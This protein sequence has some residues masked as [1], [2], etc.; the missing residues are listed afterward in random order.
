[1][2]AL[3][4]T[5]FSFTAG[6]SLHCAVRPQISPC[7]CSPHHMYANTI[8]VTCE[9]MDS[10]NHVVD[11]LQNKFTPD[12]QIWLRITHSQM[13]DFDKRQFAEMN[14]NIKNLRLNHNNLSSVPMETFQNLTK[15]EVLSLADNNIQEIPREAFE[16]MPNLG[17]LD[18]A[19]GNI[20]KIRSDDFAKIKNLQTLVIA[21]NE[22]ELLEKGC[23]PKTLTSLHIGRNKIPSLN[24]T[25]QHLTDMKMLF[26]NGNN[27]T[28]LEDELPDAPNM[29]MLMASHNNLDKLPKT[30]KNLVALD[31]CYFN[32]N[33]L[34]SLDGL[35][36]HRGSLVRLYLENNE[37]EYLA[38]DEFLKSESIDEIQL[39]SNQ[40][41]SLN[42]S[43]LYITNLRSVNLS[44]NLLREFSMQEIY[45]LM[46]LRHLD[47]SH[48]R[49]EKLT[50]RIENILDT[51]S[52]TLLYQ[53]LLGNNLLKSL[54]G[55]L[56]GLGNLRR[57]ILSNNL[58]ENIYPEDFDRM[59]ELEVLDLSNNRLKSLEAFSKVYLPTLETLNASY[60]L[61]T[62]TGK[63]FHGLN[64]LC[65]A[66]LSHNNIASMSIDLVSQT[67]CSNHGVVS[68]LEIFL[69]ENPVLCDENLPQLVGLFEM[70]HARLIGIAHCIV[71]QILPIPIDQQSQA[72]LQQPPM[73]LL[74]SVM[75]PSHPILPNQLPIIQSPS[76]VQIIVPAQ[77]IPTHSHIGEKLLNQSNDDNGKLPTD[78][79][80][81]IDENQPTTAQIETQTHDTLL[82]STTTSPQ[83]SEDEID[84]M[85]LNED[86]YNQE[87][88]DKKQQRDRSD[89]KYVESFESEKSNIP[90]RRF[91]HDNETD[92]KNVIHVLPVPKALSSPKD[93]SSSSV[94]ST[95]LDDE[96][97]E[98]Q[99]QSNISDE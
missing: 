11:V 43:L 34:R 55:V 68:K 71:P 91:D 69:Q 22:I 29:I 4:Y 1:M 94:T 3:L 85:I 70:Y 2:A 49:I 9:K 83:Y 54:D 33:K 78:N 73:E 60:N 8:S 15:V 44:G 63:D 62:T 57:L 59:E 28:T 48:N 25:L 24:G 19:R 98:I 76:I 35:F 72:L 39:A 75:Q 32:D 53:L 86:D 13:M 51:P 58:L 46:K 7:T 14:M 30:V 16:F 40:I 20:K 93:A 97:P 31:T 37:I 38:Q 23:F 61:L 56:A 99:D 80:T 90:L 47:L 12:F 87:N 45:G 17:T 64:V 77:S 41:S 66:D 96:P 10:F 79:E 81:F 89:F 18:I 5:I 95:E 84:E 50:G 42:K 21:S 65:T 27:L 6:A 92:L 26:I 74:A 67:R 36:S 52:H 82:R 88:E